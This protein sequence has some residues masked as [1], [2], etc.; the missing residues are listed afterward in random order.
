[1]N[2]HDVVVVCVM[3]VRGDVCVYKQKRRKRGIKI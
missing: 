3:V 2:K 1:M